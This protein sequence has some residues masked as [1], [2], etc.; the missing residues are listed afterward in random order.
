MSTV[1]ALV[2]DLHCNSTLGLCPPRVTLDDGGEYVASGPQRWIWRQWLAYWQAVAETPRERLLVVLNG[3]LGDTNYHPTTQLIT[4][5]DNDILQMSV[6][7]LRPMLD[8]LTDGDAVYV[9]RGTEAHSGPS[10]WVDEHVAADIGAVRASETV[11]SHWR[12][13]I[14]VEGVRF[15]IA[16]HPP[17]GGGRVPWTQQNYASSLAARVMFHA[18]AHN[19]KLPHLYIRGHLHRPYDSFEAYAV[20]ALGLPS[21]QLTTS[22]GH[23]IAGDALPVGGVIVRC[24]NGRYDLTKVYSEWPSGRYEVV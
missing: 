12:L 6:T 20:R 15:D 13:R 5:N 1:V 10:S 23:R 21:W 9:L 19:D 18:A 14:S 11:A 3:E 17:G 8:I 2:G 22:Y 7:C 24:A 4:R 16:H